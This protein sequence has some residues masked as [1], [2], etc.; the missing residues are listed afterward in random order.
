MSGKKTNKYY[1]TILDW[2][3]QQLNSGALKEGDVIPSEREL[4]SRFGVSRVPVREAFRIL[5]YIGIISNEPDGMTVKAVNMQQMNLKADFARDVTME[6]LE[7]LFEVR[8]ILETEAAY[9]AAIRRTDEDIKKMRTTLARM[10]ALLK[11]PDGDEETLIQYSHEF[12]FSVIASAKNPVLENLYRN[13]YDLLEISK[14]Y[15]LSSVS[16]STL[17]DHEAI[18]YKIELGDSA[19][20]SRYMKLHLMQALKKLQ[21]ATKE[22]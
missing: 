3:R 7:N 10:S 9:Y 14:E 22:V 11:K 12:H 1:E 16:E 20:A 17:M 4:A 2:F 15:T 6:T 18:L 19:E 21:K 13:M 8:I 5:E